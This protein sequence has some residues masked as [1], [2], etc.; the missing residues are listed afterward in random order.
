MYVDAWTDAP[1]ITHNL[2]CKQSIARPTACRYGLSHTT[3]TTEH[4]A[5]QWVASPLDAGAGKRCTDRQQIKDL[6]IAIM[7]VH[8]L[9]KGLL[10]RSRCRLWC[11]LPSYLDLS[12]VTMAAKTWPVDHA[13]KTDSK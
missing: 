7:H 3:H 6:D 12:Q 5:L 2:R 8:G 4:T 1:A 13:A 11:S 9:A 10:N